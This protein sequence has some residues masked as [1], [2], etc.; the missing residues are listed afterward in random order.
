M[1]DDPLVT[2]AQL[3]E[4][5]PSGVSSAPKYV[6]SSVDLISAADSEET[7]AIMLE[8]LKTQLSAPPPHPKSCAVLPCD[9]LRAIV[10]N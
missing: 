6:I 5:Y 10:L 1:C 9:A 7:A 8:R 3:G 2:A 4:L